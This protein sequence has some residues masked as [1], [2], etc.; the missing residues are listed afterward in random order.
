MRFICLF[1]LLFTNLS[2]VCDPIVVQGELLYLVACSDGYYFALEK[3]GKNT[4]DSTPLIIASSF[5]KTA[6]LPATAK[7]TGFR[8]SLAYQ[9][10]DCCSQA[11]IKWWHFQTVEG[12]SFRSPSKEDPTLIP[13]SVQRL[14]A[15]SFSYTDGD[16]FFSSLFGNHVKG[17]WE[18]DLHSVDF[19]VASFK[20]VCPFQI[21]PVL[22]I[23]YLDTNQ[24]LKIQAEGKIAD[25]SLFRDLIKEKF[26]VSDFFSRETLT[27]DFTGVGP[28]MSL[29]THSDLFC[30]LG[31][32]TE[33]GVSLLYGC[34]ETHD[35]ARVERLPFEE[36]KGLDLHEKR[37]SRRWCSRAMADG[38]VGLSYQCPI[39]C[40][41]FHA[42]VGWELHYL[43][44]QGM[45][46][47]DPPLQPFLSREDNDLSLQGLSVA[48]GISF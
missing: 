27:V 17:S 6:R 28:A 10:P 12:K 25:N 36:I 46:E 1:C 29:A 30:G 48:L 19:S 43:F 38:A 42:K 8:V 40:C 16:F 2:A 33:V 18:L 45:G 34:R 11:S 14:G 23:R 3:E 32:Y 20:A 5:K 21:E 24:R 4:L 47:L 26:L 13:F 15:D 35:H 44:N 31:F 7:D 9:N 41:D 22:T 39:S 37:K